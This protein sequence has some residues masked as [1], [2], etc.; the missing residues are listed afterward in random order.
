MRIINYLKKY[1]KSTD[2]LLLVFFIANLL[3]LGDAIF[4][5]FHKKFVVDVVEHNTKLGDVKGENYSIE[6]RRIDG[7]LKFSSEKFFDFV[8]VSKAPGTNLLLFAFTAFVLFQLMRIKALWYHRYFT[9]KLYASIDA[10]GY[11]AGVMFI[12]CRI[13]EIYIKK[14]VEKMSNGLLKADIDT[15]FLT[16][17]VVI[18]ILSPLLKSFA[19]QGNKLQEEQDLTI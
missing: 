6:S 7:L 16:L 15:E 10:L 14:L 2:I 11:V 18:M 9:K 4:S 3:I 19:K 8:F 13:Q 1:R 5:S 12:F 17:V